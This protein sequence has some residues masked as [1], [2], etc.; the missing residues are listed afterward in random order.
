MTEIQKHLFSLQD[1]EYKK[2]HRKLLPNIREENII[3]V[4]VPLVRKYA[5]ELYKNNGV[6]NL[7]E[8]SVQAD[9][10]MKTL[11][12]KYYEEN[13]LHA[14]LIEHATNFDTCME[15]LEKFL[16]YIDNWA[17]CDSLKPKVFKQIKSCKSDPGLNA[18][19]LHTKAIE[20]TGSEKT[21]TVRFGIGVLM[22]YFLG[23]LFTDGDIETVCGIRSEEYYVNMMRAWYLVT[24]M[25]THESEVVSI[26]EERRLDSWTH[27]KT[28][29]KAVESYRIDAELKAKLKSI[30]ISGET[31]V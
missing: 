21:Y 6:Q 28:I 11:P 22:N 29:Q 10:F 1:T 13:N 16:P 12:H 25:S 9:T 17:T 3:G 5:D 15:L 7:P 18:E 30:R 27:N 26:L 14:F 8:Y 23:K 2:F 19:R 31:Y 20:W 24:A 4:R